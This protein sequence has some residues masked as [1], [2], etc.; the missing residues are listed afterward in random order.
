MVVDTSAVLAILFGE[1]EREAFASS[2]SEAGV[3]I[4][5]TPNA[6]EASI[7]V[8]ARKGPA[9]LRELDLLL[10]AAGIDLVDFTG[11]HLALAREGYQRFGKGRHPAALNFGDCC[12]YALSIHSGEPLLFKGD[13]FARTDVRTAIEG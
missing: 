10:H 3:R 8:L 9:G 5:G 1:P 11:E 6:L 7:V 4:V 12:A 13:D 2:I